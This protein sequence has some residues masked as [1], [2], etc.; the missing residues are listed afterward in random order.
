MS[1]WSARYVRI[2][3]RQDDV[4]RLQPLV[5]AG[6]SVRAEEGAA[7]AAWS[8]PSPAFEPADLTSLSRDFGEAIALAVQTVADL[9]VYDRFVDGRRVRGLTYAGEAGWVRVVG[10][11]D[12]WEERVLFSEGKLAELSEELE[13][14]FEDEELA[15]QKREL[16]R[17]WKLGRLQEGSARPPADPAGLTRAIEKHFGLPGLGKDARRG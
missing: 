7:F 9:V 12:P 10:E 13:E 5:D 11:P 4:A 3:D 8:L 15:Q 17:V 2:R 6:A 14:D 16:E 1:A